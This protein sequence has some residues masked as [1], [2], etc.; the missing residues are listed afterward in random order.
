[1]QT[2]T[3]GARIAKLEA[4]QA[5]E[6]ASTRMGGEVDEETVKIVEKLLD[7]KPADRDD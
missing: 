4:T 6:K 1:M 5:V 2:A 3:N 7:D